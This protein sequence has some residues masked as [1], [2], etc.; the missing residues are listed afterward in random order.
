[1]TRR[2][3]LVLL[4]VFSW[5]QAAQPR[6]VR[7]AVFPH[8][9]ATFQDAGGQARGFY[10]DM[11]EE[12]ARAKGWQ[13]QYLQGSFAEGLELVRRG[14]ADLATSVAFSEERAQ[15]LDYGHEVT[16]TVWSILYA[17]PKIPIQSVF[18]VRGRRVAVMKSLSDTAGLS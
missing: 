8:K 4:A 6:V 1:M 17:N 7:V 9:P 3:L 2:I 18:D 10:I 16:F 5:V 14:E 12:V 15:Y 11:I 13:L